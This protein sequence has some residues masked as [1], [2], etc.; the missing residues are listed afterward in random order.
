VLLLAAC[1]QARPGVQVDAGLACTACGACD[2]SVVVTSALHVS[3]SVQYDDLPPAGGPHNSCWGTWGVHDTALPP[4]RWVHNL[5]HGGVVF[6][7]HCD[8][9]C[10]DEVEQLAALVSETPRTLLTPYDQLP[11]RFGVVAWGHRLVSDCFDLG[12]FQTFYTEHFNHG[13]E[14]IASEPAAAC[15]QFPEL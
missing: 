1:D 10:P 4:E 15:D 8:D 5:E 9:G 14:A 2:E 13:L 11:K 6:L 12:A 3:G 7:Y